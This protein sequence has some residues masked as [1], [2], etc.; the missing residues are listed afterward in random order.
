[1]SPPYTPGDRRRSV[2]AGRDRILA[3]AREVLHLDRVASFSVDAVAKR[4]GVTRMTVYNQF[5]SRAGLLGEL[6]DGL[7]ER[8]AFAEMP[9]AFAETDLG[10][11]FDA[12]VAIFGRFYT[13]NRAVMVRL[14]AV[15][16]TDPDLDEAM[17]S[18][19]ERRRR[20]IEAVIRLQGSGLRPAVASA[21]LVT[22]LDVLLNFQTFHAVAGPD[23]TPAD[24]V[25]HMRRLVRAVLGLTSRVAARKAGGRRRKPGGS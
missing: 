15:A 12:L 5:G 24:V 4:A 16:G 22:T 19:N 13:T 11:A 25:P 6:F 1:M 9:A 14:V 10:K 7:I 8:E 20:A 17:R 3:A 21:E 18:R 2:D 23:R